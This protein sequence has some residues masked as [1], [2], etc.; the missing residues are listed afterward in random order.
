MA[1]V[2]IRDLLDNVY[3]ATVK[4][5]FDEVAED[6]P[7]L[8]VS[9]DSNCKLTLTI[10]TDLVANMQ[11]S[12]STSSI[13]ARNATFNGTVL[14]STTGTSTVSSVRLLIA[15]TDTF[16]LVW[17]KQYYSNYNF[18]QVLYE[19]LSDEKFASAY[20]GSSTSSMNVSTLYNIDNKSFNRWTFNS[21]YA[22]PTGYVDYMD[23]TI[24]A[25]GVSRIPIDTNFIYALSPANF[26]ANT[27][28]TI[29]NKDYLAI[30]AQFLIP[31][32]D[33]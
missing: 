14:N 29:D 16:F 12:E 23:S 27:I 4:A 5:V 3:F 10:D 24:L 2:I 19:K 28:I 30:N 11:L 20:M 25:N 22:L 8:S 17:I 33:E 18:F 32:D 9:D 13:G 7:I 1:K 6:C 21:G 31:I 26:T 15:Y